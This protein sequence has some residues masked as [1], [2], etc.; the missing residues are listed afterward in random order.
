M[1]RA[2]RR[3]ALREA[4]PLV[5]NPVALHR[6]QSEFVNSGALIRGYVGGRGAGKSHVGAY[7]VYRRA[8]AD[9]FYMIAAPTYPMLTD[10]SLRSFVETGERIGYLEKTWKGSS[11][12]ARIRTFDR[13]TEEWGTAEVAFRSTSDPEKLRGPNL[14]GIWFDEASIM[15]EDAFN[16]GMA[17]LR[18][19][20]EQGWISMTF[21][22]KGKQHWTY[23]K[24]FDTDGR[25]KKGT[26]LVQSSTADN[27]ALPPEFFEVMLDQYGESSALSRQELEG[28]F[29]ELEGLLFQRAWFKLIKRDAIPREGERVRYWDKAGT[30]DGGCFSVGTLI[31]QHRKAFYIEDVVRGQWSP[32]KRNRIMKE[33]AAMDA[34]KYNNEVKIWMEQEGGSGG[35]ESALISVSDLAGYP[36]FLDSPSGDKATRAQPLSAQAE[37]GNVYVAEEAWTRDWLDELCTF[38]E[39]KFKDQVDSASGAFNKTTLGSMN[40]AMVSGKVLNWSPDMKNTDADKLSGKSIK[41]DD[42]VATQTRNAQT[43]ALMK[44]LLRRGVRG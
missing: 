11:P 5:A 7:D 33:T 15:V 26:H 25:Q 4:A 28:L 13:E 21:T 20:G 34:K 31:C 42:I 2:A 14:S 39:S 32:A 16:I 18:E 41:A 35:K 1:V 9:R 30:D 19:G 6:K 3:N 22:P 29:V 24:F 10:S 38:P 44:H 27:P 37:N 23:E 36:V 12:R 8:K 40:R 17:T 43:A